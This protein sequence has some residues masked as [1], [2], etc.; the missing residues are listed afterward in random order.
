MLTELK[1]GDNAKIIAIDAR[2]QHWHHKHHQHYHFHQHHFRQKL[3][4]RGITEGSI[5]RVISNM[6]PVTVEVDRNIVSIGRGMAQKIR[7]MRV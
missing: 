6:G 5:V 3:S 1:P 4:L 7:V 2:D